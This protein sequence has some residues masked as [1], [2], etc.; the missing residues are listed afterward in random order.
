[1]ALGEEIEEKERLLDYKNYHDYKSELES[2][3]DKQT[4]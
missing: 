4:A 1:M 2:L 3:E